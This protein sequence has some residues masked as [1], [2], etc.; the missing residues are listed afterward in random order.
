[1]SLALFFIGLTLVAIIVDVFCLK[2]TTLFVVFAYYT[3]MW[4]LQ[5]IH[6]FPRD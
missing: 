3:G 1:V 4:F 2:V 6:L 5:L